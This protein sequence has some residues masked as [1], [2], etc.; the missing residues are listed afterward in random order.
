M[1]QQ[2][3][4]VRVMQIGFIVFA[5]LLFWMMHIIKPQSG[6]SEPPVFYGSIAAIGVAAGFIGIFMQRQIMKSSAKRLL[7]GTRPTSAQRWLAGN[8]A[9]LA[10]ANS[11]CL[12]GFMLHVLGAPERWALALVALGVLFMLVSPGKPAADEPASSPYGTIEY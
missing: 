7:D 4:V 5:A 8:V 6:S 10:F 2:Q 3:R 11:T 1:V 12:F 9:R